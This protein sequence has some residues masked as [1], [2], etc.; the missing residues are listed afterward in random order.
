MSGQ[1]ALWKRFEAWTWPVFK[2]PAFIGHRLWQAF[3][4]DAEAAGEPPSWE[5]YYED[6]LRSYAPFSRSV[7]IEARYLR[8]IA[9]FARRNRVPLWFVLAPVADQFRDG[10]TRPQDFVKNILAAEG[11]AVLDL[12]VSMREI[13]DL[14][15][16][17]LPE[18]YGHWSPAGHA[19]AARQVAKF[20]R[21]ER[22]FD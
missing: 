7:E 15:A 1:P 12:M 18:D 13:P 8:E 20:A 3:G 21:F 19:F 9:G 16:L 5:A 11:V 4:S 17:Y 22:V 2:S 10:R 6:C 14:T